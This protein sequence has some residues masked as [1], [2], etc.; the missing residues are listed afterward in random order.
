VSLRPRKGARRGGPFVELVL[1]PWRGF[2]QHD[3]GSTGSS[4]AS[5]HTNSDILRSEELRVAIFY[6]KLQDRLM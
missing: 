1:E 5:P 4:N 6:A 2:G 3:S